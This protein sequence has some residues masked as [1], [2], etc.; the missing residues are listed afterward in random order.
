MKTRLKTLSLFKKSTLLSI[1]SIL[2][3]SFP[4]VEGNSLA[5]EVKQSAGGRVTQNATVPTSFQDYHKQCLQRATGEGLAQD[6]AQDLCNCT[7]KTFQSRY[8]FSQFRAIVAKS[9]T[10]RTAART[11]TQVGETCFDQ[12][13][14]E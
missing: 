7:I 4:I 12:V 3:L 10:D 6:I 13:L 5:K 8:N 11:L 2:L 9:K 1:S 14:Y